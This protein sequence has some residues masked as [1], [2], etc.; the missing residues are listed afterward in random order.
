MDALKQSLQVNPAFPEG[1]PARRA[2]ALAGQVASHACDLDPEL[3]HRHGKRRLAGASSYHS[4]RLWLAHF[5]C[6]TL[7]GRTREITPLH[8]AHGEGREQA[9]PA[10]QAI[11][12][13][14]LAFLDAASGL[15]TLVILLDH[16]AELATSPPE[17]RASWQVVISIEVSKI[18]SSGSSPCGVSSSHTRPTQMGKAAS[19]LRRASWRGGRSASGI[20]ERCKV[21]GRALRP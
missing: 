20:H 3:A 17:A 21:V 10:D 4:H 18:H 19:L 16:E 2:I 15:Q 12:T 11:C 8:Q 13:V 14:H 1:F 9:Q 7:W 6:M 5:L